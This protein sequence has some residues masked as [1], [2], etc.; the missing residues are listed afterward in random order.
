MA[1]LKIRVAKMGDLERLVEIYNHYVAHTHITFHTE[2]FTVDQRRDW[3]DQ[4]AL[5]GP[6]RLLVA[7]T[8]QGVVGYASSTAFKARAAYRSGF[9]R[10]R[11]KRFS[12]DDG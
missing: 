3:F 7:E 10:E 6:H 11:D 1:E 2:E 9:D 8:D 4:F 5:T 12:D